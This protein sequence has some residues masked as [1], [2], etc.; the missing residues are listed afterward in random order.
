MKRK[1]YADMNCSIARTLDI[2]GDPW[3]LLVVRD[4]FW[5]FHRFEE[6]QKR[7]GIARNTL[8]DRLNVLVDHGIATK[9]A[10]QDNPTRHEYR[11]TPKGRALH[12]VIVTLMSWGDQWSGI[13]E[14][15]VQLV[16]VPSGR[17]VSAILVDAETG[18]PLENLRVRA[19]PVAEVSD[20]PDTANPS[21]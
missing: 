3:T 12:P 17:V 8:T 1:S 18:E 19:K 10:Y 20:E 5:G 2:V 13:E 11:L 21:P 15:P 14:P 4:M 9:V 6:F 7:L 16:E